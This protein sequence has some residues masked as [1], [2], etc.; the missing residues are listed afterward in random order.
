[1][2]ERCVAARCSNV[3]DPKKHISMHKIPFFG[4][5]CPIK[6]KRRKR[7]IDFVLER[8]KMW[9]PGKTSSL[10]S[11]HFTADDFERPLNME[12]NLKRELKK[13]SIGFCVYP[14]IHA[15]RE[16]EDD[17]PPSK[18]SRDKRMVRKN[19]HTCSW[20]SLWFFS[21][22]L[23]LVHVSLMFKKDHYNWF[24]FCTDRSICEVSHQNA[25]RTWSDGTCYFRSFHELSGGKQSIIKIMN[26]FYFRVYLGILEELW[27]VTNSYVL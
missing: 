24:F 25:G 7:W 3:A 6:Q 11:K 21:E 27:L 23:L 13:D 9:V 14:T 18:R 12:L 2:P 1:M 17:E 4:E 10:C 19:S 22:I 26:D 20:H 16:G 5:N 15:K 8:R